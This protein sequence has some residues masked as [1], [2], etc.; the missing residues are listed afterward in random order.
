MQTLNREMDFALSLVREAGEIVLR[1][2]EQKISAS[3]KSDNT[4]VTLADTECER[5]LRDKIRSAF[6]QD[7]LLGEEEGLSAVGGATQ[8][9]KRKW[10][11]DPIDGTYNFARQVP[12]FSTL[13]A[14]EEEGQIVL[15]IVHAPA[16]GETYW[17][18][19]DGGAFRNGQRIQVSTISD[20]AAS[21]FVFG[22]PSRILSDGLWEG[23]KRVIVTT[24]RQRAFGDYLNFAHVFDG[25]AEAVLEIGVKPW[26]LA[27]MKII[28]EEAG[29]RFSDL[30]GGASIYTGSCLVSNGILHEELLK[31]LLGD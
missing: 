16:M 19:R 4:P 21:Q 20:I 26:D 8:A 3:M 15:G 12:I 7:D 22:A 28:A 18:Q 13:L 11:I 23:L 9:S 17:A 5:F 29:G 14:L 2:Y 30:S 6:P 24:Y 10:I 25:R 31:L 1:Y 27:P